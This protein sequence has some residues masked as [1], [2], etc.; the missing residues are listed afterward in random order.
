LSLLLPLAGC[1]PVGTSK[2]LLGK[3]E[4]RPDTFAAQAQRDPIPTAPGYRAPAPPQGAAVSASK[5]PAGQVAP[6]QVSQTTDLESHD[7]VVTL[8]F[9]R[10]GRVRMEL[11]GAQPIEGAWRVLSTDVGVS[12]IEIVDQP[13]SVAPQADQPDTDRPA[14]VKRRFALKWNNE[15]DGFTL[16]EEGADPRF[17]WLYFKRAE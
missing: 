17:G 15:A 11:N 8:D 16:R 9:Q 5:A 4:G 1:G 10:Q 7:F 13:P 2:Q 12:V 6:L 3:W 14:A